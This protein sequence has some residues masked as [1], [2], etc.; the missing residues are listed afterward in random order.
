[1]RRG[2][3][4]CR[5]VTRYRGC[6]AELG[7]SETSLGNWVRAYRKSTRKTSRHCSYPSGRGS[8]SWSARTVSL[9]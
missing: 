7:V 9:E 2:P 3:D 5:D 8:A 1:M 4:G 6:G